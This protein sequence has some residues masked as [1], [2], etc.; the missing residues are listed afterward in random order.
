VTEGVRAEEAGAT[1]GVRGGATG[2]TEG[3]EAR[4]GERD[5]GPRGGI[6]GARWSARA[7]ARRGTYEDEGEFLSI[8]WKEDLDSR[9][10][11]GF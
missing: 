2:E 4:E 9:Y 6:R 1:E 8:D 7:G 3:D 11:G 5:R 10:D